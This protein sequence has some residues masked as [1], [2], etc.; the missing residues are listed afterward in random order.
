[1]VR[2]TGT[3]LS[4][5][6][7]SRIQFQFTSHAEEWSPVHRMW[8]RLQ[9]MLSELSQKKNSHEKALQKNKLDALRPQ[10]AKPVTLWE[11]QRP[12]AGHI[13]YCSTL[14]LHWYS[15]KEYRLEK[16]D[17]ESPVLERLRPRASR[18]S[19]TYQIC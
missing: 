5:I 4:L 14:I 12:R 19:L 6:H 8:W 3:N 18:R 10:I 17:N 15:P 11:Q 1:I 16:E 13:C 7:C 2:K 9:L